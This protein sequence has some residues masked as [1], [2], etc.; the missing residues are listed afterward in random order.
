M[1]KEKLLVDAK[2]ESTVA[3]RVLVSDKP[4]Q[5]GA[6]YGKVGQKII[7]SLAG[8]PKYPAEIARTLGVQHQT[9]YYHI[10]RLEQAGLISKVRSRMIRGGEA[11]LFSLSSDGYAVE[12]AVE[13][14][15]IPSIPA[16]SRSSAFGRFFS[17]FTKDGALDGWLV[18]G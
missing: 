12:F 18:V 5:F 3:K 8:G 15:R 17:E 10:R 16:A 1:A 6:A 9:V 7:S 14:E 4:D 13:G 2:L 11:N